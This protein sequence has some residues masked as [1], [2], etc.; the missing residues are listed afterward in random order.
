MLS[1]GSDQNKTND[2]RLQHTDDVAAPESCFIA[3]FVSSG[4][5]LYSKN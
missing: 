3:I 4:Y 2:P 1:H 5:Q